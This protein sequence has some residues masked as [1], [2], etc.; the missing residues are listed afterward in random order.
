MSA[1]RVAGAL[2]AVVVGVVAGGMAGILVPVPGCSD[3]R[4][5]PRPEFTCSVKVS[6]LPEQ[7]QPE[8]GVHAFAYRSRSATAAT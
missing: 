3:N 2:R 7:S 1:A 4:R 6:P 5:M 8:T